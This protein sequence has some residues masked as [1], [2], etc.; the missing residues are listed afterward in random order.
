[1]ETAA[2]PP[3]MLCSQS[4]S[5][6]RSA[7]IVERKSRQMKSDGII[8]LVGMVLCEMETLLTFCNASV[9]RHSMLKRPNDPGSATRRTGRNDGHRDAP[10]GFAA[11]YG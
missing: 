6:E 4:N 1:M 3:V 9:A 8:R 5:I 11:A 10:T 7:G 2:L